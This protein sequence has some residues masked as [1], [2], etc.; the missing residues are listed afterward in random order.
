M[1]SITEYLN[2]KR[3][4]YTSLSEYMTEAEDSTKQLR[5]TPGNLENAAETVDSIVTI[6][7]NNG[8]YAERVEGGVL[9]KGTKENHNKFTEIQDIIQQYVDGL[10]GKEDVDTEKLEKVA[11]QMNK[12]NDWLDAMNAKSEEE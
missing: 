5:F 3:S 8:I 10:T 11:K 4:E 9:L 7:E 6:A 1:K 12:L 2:E